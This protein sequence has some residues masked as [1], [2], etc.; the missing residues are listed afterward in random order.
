MIA[1]LAFWACWVAAAIANSLTDWH[2]FFAKSA[3]WLNKYKQPLQP[4][5]RTLYYRLIGVEYKEKFPLST[6]ILVFLT[7]KFHLFQFI[8]TSFLIATLTIG[9]YGHFTFHWTFPAALIVSW[10]LVTHVSYILIVQHDRHK[11]T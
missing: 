9:H 8:Q 11:A 5:P 1:Q 10:G 6:N 4:A 3:D 2:G 7:D